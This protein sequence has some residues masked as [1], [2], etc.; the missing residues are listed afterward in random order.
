MT[1]H[2]LLRPRIELSEDGESA[3]GVCYL[4]AILDQRPASS[5]PGSDERERVMLGGVYAHQFKRVEGRWLIA[6]SV[7]DLSFDHLLRGATSLDRS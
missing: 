5:P 2:Y 1:L 6:S 4:L 7:C 3:T